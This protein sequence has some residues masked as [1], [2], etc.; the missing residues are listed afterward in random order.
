MMRLAILKRDTRGTA[1]IEMAIIFPVLVGLI[2]GIFQLGILFQAQAGM[3]HA[4]GEAARYA[5]LYPAPSDTA[6][7]AKVTAKAFGTYNGTLSPLVV[8]N[9]KSDG[10]AAATAAETK[11]KVLSLTYTQPANFLFLTLPN[12]TLTRTKKV[13]VGV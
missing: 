2:W 7:K 3:Q 4:L 1:A 13:Y 10:T 9:Y 8:N 6:I 12:M 11:Y 5:T